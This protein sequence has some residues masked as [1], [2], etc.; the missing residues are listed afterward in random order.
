MRGHDSVY[1][2]G[3]D[4]IRERCAGS[5]ILGA[6][7]EDIFRARTTHGEKKPTAMGRL[8]DSAHVRGPWQ[9]LRETG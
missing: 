5:G 2:G 4:M 1:V 6:T 8:N 9:N 7:P 3:L